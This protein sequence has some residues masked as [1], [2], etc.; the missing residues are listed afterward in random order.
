MIAEI[1]PD[2][3][4]VEEA[5]GDLPEAELFPEEEAVVARATVARWRGRGNS[6]SS[7]S[8]ARNSWALA[9]IV[10]SPGCSPS[11]APGGLSGLIFTNS[12]RAGSSQ[13]T[14]RLPCLRMVHRRILTMSDSYPPYWF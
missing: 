11:A 2:R 9:A 13:T 5:F 6:V 14:L 8:A 12:G 7:S 3:V 4:V 10:M 1:L